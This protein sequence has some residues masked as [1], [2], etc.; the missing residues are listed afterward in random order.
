MASHHFLIAIVSFY[1]LII[2]TGDNGIHFFMVELRE[3]TPPPRLSSE[4]ILNRVCMLP[5]ITF[6]TRHV[7]QKLPGFGVEHNWV[8]RSIF[9]ELPYW[10]TNLIRHNLDVMHIEKNVFENIFNTIMDIKNKTKDN[11]KARKDLERYYSRPHLHLKSYNDKLCKPK[12]SYAL[13]IK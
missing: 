7:K 4:E 3:I 12:A 9:W 6:G 11:A 2:N 10:H 1:P 5:D 8:K 13:T